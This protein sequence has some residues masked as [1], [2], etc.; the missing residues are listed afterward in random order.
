MQLLDSCADDVQGAL[1]LVRMELSEKVCPLVQQLRSDSKSI[2]LNAVKALESLA[3]SLANEQ[4]I[5]ASG[6]TLALLQLVRS[7]MPRWVATCLGL[8]TGLMH[9][10]LL[11]TSDSPVQL[12][13]TL[14]PAILHPLQ[15]IQ[16][17]SRG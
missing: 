13:T 6:G 17:C 15:A 5:A 3:A 9:S 11:A 2:Q 14:T 1:A 12:R 10:F 7:R 8:L 4:A 16:P